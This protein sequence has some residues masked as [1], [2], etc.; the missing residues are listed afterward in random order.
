MNNY[1]K[2]ELQKHSS[3]KNPSRLFS[4]MNI[5]NETLI[6]RMKNK[7]HYSIKPL[8]YENPKDINLNDIFIRLVN[9]NIL[10]NGENNIYIKLSEE[11]I[12]QRQNVIKS[13][14]KFIYLNKIGYGIFY[15]IIFLFDILI[16]LDN[17]VKV[18]QNYEELG[19]GSTILMIK[20]MHE[21]NKLIYVNIFQNFYERK[22]YS[23]I[24]LKQI[25]I[26]CLKLINYYLNFPT[27]LLYMELYFL[28]GFLFKKDNIKTDTCFKLYSMALNILEKILTTSN[29][30]TKYSLINFVS[31][32]ISY[33]RQNYG[34]EKWPNI[35][36]KTF[37]ISETNFGNVI[38]D[39]I[40]TED[41]LNIKNMSVKNKK[42]IIFSRYKEKIE[43]EKNKQ[44][45]NK[46]IN[47]HHINK[48]IKVNKNNFK[49]EK[50]NSQINIFKIN[51]N[52]MNINLNYRTTEEIKNSALFRKIT[53]KYNK[54]LKDLNL[55]NS[56]NNINQKIVLNTEIGREKTLENKK[57]KNAY[58]TPDKI[59]NNNQDI[60]ERDK[61]EN[62]TINL[63]NKHI[64]NNSNIAISNKNNNFF[65]YEQE[66][67]V[68]YN[69]EETNECDLSKDLNNDIKKK[70]INIDKN[71]E[72]KIYKKFRNNISEEINTE[73]NLNEKEEIK[74]KLKEFRYQKKSINE[75]KKI[76]TETDLILGNGDSMNN[77]SKTI[78][79]NIYKKNFLYMNNKSSMNFKNSNNEQNNLIRK[80]SEEIFVK[81][82]CL[83]RLSSCNNKFKGKIYFGH[84]K[85]DDYSNE[86]TSENSHNFSIRRNYFRLKRLKDSS[87]NIRNENITTFSGNNNELNNNTKNENSHI[88]RCNIKFKEN[89][90][91]IND[92][93]RNN[94][95]SRYSKFKDCL[96]I[97]SIDRR[98]RKS[99]NFNCVDKDKIQ[100]ENN[101][102]R[103][104]I[105]NHYRSKNIIINNNI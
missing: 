44:Q 58:K 30:Y 65:D 47:I 29:E 79:N 27:P 45:E 87:I 63:N 9:S 34:L 31:G 96:K 93:D 37:G 69:R 33:C 56:S 54:N 3:M 92:K 98:F 86:T 51:N 83:N 23:K 52:S 103:F 85:E 62:I 49:E 72:R 64:R 100:S 71:E 36:V 8:S 91:N 20:Y 55:S 46:K 76:N 77:I 68:L 84:N 82:I 43:D 104:E 18:I 22:Y 6:T 70:F 5:D 102:K 80:K 38:H 7:N 89:L 41:N 48:D 105:R 88:I 99:I 12:I 14:K 10:F 73:I 16:Y 75:H 60:K 19:L 57:L 81:N 2:Y 59:T 21:E 50:G 61:K 40:C 39:L 26:L 74:V 32:I 11:Q 53:I 97:G 66:H 24:L 35:L 25:E 42:N 94:N 28:N 101:T 4:K 67:Q 1:E 15:N 78:I 13:I 90:K 17:K 95:G